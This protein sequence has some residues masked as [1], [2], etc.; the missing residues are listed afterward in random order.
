MRYTLDSLNQELR[1][2][3][4]F[5]MEE[6]LFAILEINGTLTVLK[7]PEYRPVIHKDLWISTN[8]ESWLP[9]E[10]IMDGQI[11]YKN[12]KENK[13]TKEWLVQELIKRNLQEGDVLYAV[14]GSNGQL[15][16]DTYNDFIQSPVDKE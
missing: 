16:I 15:Y 5:D 10:L 12:L 4:V 6:V 1:E 14:F 8:P 3:S 2:Q 7:K 11:I 13:L 9:I